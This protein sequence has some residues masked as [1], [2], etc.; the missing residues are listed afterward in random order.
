MISFKWN[1][2]QYDVK[3]G[4]THRMHTNYKPLTMHNQ[5]WVSIGHALDIT[6]FKI[7]QVTEKLL[8][9]G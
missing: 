9:F 2:Q 5:F 6:Y 3:C 1:A 4:H 7:E 8:S